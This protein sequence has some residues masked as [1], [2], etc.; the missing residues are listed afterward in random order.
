MSNPTEVNIDPKNPNPNLGGWAKLIARGGT[1]TLV[2]QDGKEWW[3]RN[4]YVGEER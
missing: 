4:T 2:S 3:V 1:H